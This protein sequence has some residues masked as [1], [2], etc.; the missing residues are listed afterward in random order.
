MGP[1]PL[2]PTREAEGEREGGGRLLIVEE[3]PF[4]RLRS[5]S[6]I[7]Q[8]KE[9]AARSFSKRFSEAIAPHRNAFSIGTIPFWPIACIASRH[10]DE[11]KLI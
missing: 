11:R 4:E 7:L 1:F 5:P 10:D 9:V 8:R 2:S 3:R 6:Q